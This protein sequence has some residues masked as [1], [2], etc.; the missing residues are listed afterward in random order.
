MI[1]IL[2]ESGRSAVRREYLLR[3]I[4]A[5]LFMASAVALCAGIMLIPSYL[6]ATLSQ[7]QATE[8]ETRI[9]KAKTEAQ[10]G[11]IAVLSQANEQIKA[12]DLFLSARPPSFIM[13]SVLASASKDITIGRISY[14]SVDETLT[15]SGKASSREELLSFVEVIK[16]VPGIASAE[17]PVGDLAK[18]TDVSFNIAA[19]LSKEY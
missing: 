14:S 15:F 11:D 3:L 6:F 19:T 2:P 5:S 7:R 13:R 9:S 1:N 17:L 18:N 8:E 12:L 4:A 10:T 16:K